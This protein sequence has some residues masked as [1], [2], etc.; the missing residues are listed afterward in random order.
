MLSYRIDPVAGIVYIEGDQA[1]TR[2]EFSA[3]LGAVRADPTYRP[4]FGFLRD[5]RGMAPMETSLVH[6][7]VASLLAF[8]GPDAGRWAFV[9]TDPAN[10]GM[11]RMTELLVGVSPS[12]VAIFDNL[13]DAERWLTPRP[14]AAPEPA[15]PADRRRNPVTEYFRFDFAGASEASETA[16]RLVEFM[17]SKS[18]RWVEKPDSPVILIG[19]PASRPPSLYLSPGALAAARAAGM[20]LGSW[21]TRVPANQLPPGLT[22]VFEL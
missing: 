17:L 5:R 10:Y 7:D 1:G 2:E 16:R 9:I 3:V 4:G 20:S 22:T 13:E 6:S 21:P 15:D 8:F 12:Q 11:A 14:A 19:R 18:P